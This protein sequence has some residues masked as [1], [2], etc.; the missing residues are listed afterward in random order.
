VTTTL[1]EILKP[2]RMT[3]T[4]IWFALVAA[5]P[6]Y[7]VVATMVAR[8]GTDRP[9][10]EPTH[11]TAFAALS[12]LLAAASLLVQ[13]LIPTATT[14][15]K[16]MAES[17]DPE[18][19]ARDP[20]KGKV[21]AALADKIRQLDPTERRILLLRPLFQI[22]VI[23]RCAL[24]EAVGICGFMLVLLGHEPQTLFPFAA[25]SFVLLLLAFPRF[26]RFIER[27]TEMQRA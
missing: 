24:A 3:V 5:M 4:I 17:T 23:V 14:I 9:E 25:A 2:F 1:S 22:H 13:R 15:A 19:M 20:E 11:V 21:D 16:A 10:P 18:A 26:D 12:V 27:A 7:V 8:G 6:T